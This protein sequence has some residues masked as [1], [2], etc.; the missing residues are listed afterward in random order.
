MKFNLKTAAV[1]LGIFA[2]GPLQSRAQS[3]AQPLHTH[4]TSYKAAVGDFGDHLYKMAADKVHE[5]GYYMP[6]AT[7][8][9]LQRLISAGVE[10]MFT[11]GLTEEKYTKQAEDNLMR[12]V[13]VMVDDA[14]T[15]GVANALDLISFRAA[16]GMVCP[17][18]WPFC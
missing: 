11:A 1:I 16:Q 15:R 4:V 10:K 14:K 5:E 13:T 17:N 8:N 3:L 7:K 6:Y 2:A 12:F 18:G 9:S